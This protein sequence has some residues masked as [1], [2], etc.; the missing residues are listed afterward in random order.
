[1]TV[2]SDVTVDWSVSPRIITVLS[3][4]AEITIQDLVDTCRELEDDVQNLTFAHLINAAGK[5]DLGGGVRVGVTATL[6]NAVL[7]FETRPGPTYAQCR[8][9][10]GNLVALDA[11][12]TNI[13]PIYPTAFTQVLTTSSS[14]ATL[15]ELSDIQYSSFNGGITVDVT[16]P[17]AGT[18]YPTGTPRRPVNNMAD[19]LAIANDRGFTSFFVVGNA[20]LGSGL[21][22][23]GK[24]FV[25]ESKSRTLLTLESGANLTNC[26]F[27]DANVTG[28][29][30]MGARL[31]S[32]R[33]ESLSYINGYIEECVLH[34]LISIS[35]D[36]HLLNCWGGEPG[37]A[38]VLDLGGTSSKVSLWN[39]AGQISLRNKTQPQVASIE[40]NSGY[41]II[42]STV[43]AGAVTV[44]G[45]GRLTNNATGTA[46]VIDE[47]LNPPG[48]AEAVWQDALLSNAALGQNAA[49]ML[50]ELYKLAGLDPSKPLVVT[51]TSRRIP[52]DGSDIS[53]TIDENAGTVTVTRT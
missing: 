32:C 4:S 43:T 33:I 47:T 38:P 39:Y 19:A 14:S 26:E 40:L 15:Q 24:T 16:S 51:S 25:G 3:P 21:D 5:D 37:S 12:G 29:L 42:E 46:T 1:M 30:D 11:T 44:R 41:V 53:Q 34:G 6:Q 27:R 20:V 31:I 36:I 17:Y 35:G 13:S 9:T 18:E 50:L 49:K 45:V 8:V 7:A 23:S 28:V 52:G 48:V 2:R 10:G 22:F